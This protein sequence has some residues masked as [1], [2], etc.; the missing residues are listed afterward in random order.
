MKNKIYII[1]FCYFATVSCNFFQPVS[2]NPDE[3]YTKMFGGKV[4][5]FDSQRGVA[6]EIL[7]TA[8]AYVLGHTNYITSD[9]QLYLMRL[10]NAG[11]QIWA[12]SYTSTGFD[13]EAVQMMLTEDKQHLLLLGN[14]IVG[15][16]VKIQIVKVDLDG[17]QVG[18]AKTLGGSGNYT[19]VNMSTIEGSTNFLVVGTQEIMVNGT[20]VKR[21]YA[22]ELDLNIDFVWEKSYNFNDRA[23][24]EHGI[25]IMEYNDNVLVLGRS[26]G[27]N[28]TERP[29][30]IEGKRTSIGEELQSKILFKNQNPSF[31]IIM[32]KDMI[33]NGGSDFTILCDVKNE[34]HLIKAIINSE[35]SILVDANGNTQEISTE[36]KPEGFSL[37]QNGDFLI[38]GVAGKEIGLIKI[39]ATT[40]ENLWGTGITRRFGAIHED[41]NIGSQVIEQADNTIL[42]VGTLNFD[43]TPMIGVIKTN[44]S[45]EMY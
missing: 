24:E 1:I 22:T 38:T 19:A 36:L 28:D 6:I 15:D 5:N 26:V 45:G 42:M 27:E 23:K 41:S 2:P 3:F 17:N 21:I 25:A 7:D 40:G 29:I 44:Q 4:E 13:V 9:K 35:Q 33:L 14:K 20:I 16:D 32:A 8:G 39:E 18:D 12:K 11:N 43:G 34:T 30:I 31:P 10:D 37:T